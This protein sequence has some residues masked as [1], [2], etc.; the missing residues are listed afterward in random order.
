MWKSALAIGAALLLLG[1]SAGAQDR[2]RTCVTDVKKHCADVEPGQGRI[3]GC[4]KQHLTEL[5]A[6]CQNL[7]AEAT[8]AAKACAADLKQQ[9]ADA[10]RRVAK[11]ACVKSALGNLSD[12][13][14]SAVSQIAAGRK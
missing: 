2:A 14:K 9:C 4:V 11:I 3:A 13:C 12:G 5:S 1:A 6:P 7:V 8:T 10:R